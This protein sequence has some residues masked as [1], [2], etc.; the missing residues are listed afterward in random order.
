MSWIDNIDLG[1]F[2]VLVP[3]NESIVIKSVCVHHEYLP[4]SNFSPSLLAYN[5]AII[6][7]FPLSFAARQWRSCPSDYAFLT[8]FEASYY[9]KT[10]KQEE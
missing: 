9:E 2:G 8:D 5:G 4:V 7:P 10:L 1:F 3:S 6:K